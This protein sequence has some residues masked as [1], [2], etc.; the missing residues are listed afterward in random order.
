MLRRIGNHFLTLKPWEITNINNLTEL[1]ITTRLISIKKFSTENIKFDTT[2]D[3]FESNFHDQV[4]KHF[5]TSDLKKKWTDTDSMIYSNLKF[6]DYQ[7]VHDT[8]D[9]L[10]S[11]QSMSEYKIRF[12]NILSEFLTRSPLMDQFI[13]NRHN[14]PILVNNLTIKDF[15]AHMQ[16][17]ANED[18]ELL[19][20]NII[21][22]C[23]LDIQVKSK[24]DVELSYYYM[25]LAESFNKFFLLKRFGIKSTI[26]LLNSKNINVLKNFCSFKKKRLT[27]T[28][29]IQVYLTHNI[30]FNWFSKLN[31]TS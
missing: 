6:A 16:T 25:E 17:K 29:L 26:F 10:K 18:F 20:A 8:L 22:K 23:I 21:L 28:T 14:W 31:V 5:L 9:R 27:L 3:G 1:R 12:D 2:G 11:I 15:P 24:S 13:T 7:K 4:D 19:L 30:S